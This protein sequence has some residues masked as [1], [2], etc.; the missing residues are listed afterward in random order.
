[1]S[2]IRLPLPAVRCIE[3]RDTP[4]ALY[5]FCAFRA[6]R[7]VNDD[8]LFA[9]ACAIERRVME[10]RQMIEGQTA[11]FERMGRDE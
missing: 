3:P 8:D 11:A 5:D 10:L 1:M 4:A 9:V 6:A 7:M 2:V